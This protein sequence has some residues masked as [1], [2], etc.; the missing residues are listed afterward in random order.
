MDM[1]IYNLIQ[2]QRSPLSR[3][4]FRHWPPDN[5]SHDDD[6]IIE[7]QSPMFAQVL[8][9]LKSNGAWRFCVD[10]R[11][12][13]FSLRLAHFQHQGNALLNNSSSES[14]KTELE[15]LNSFAV[16]DLTS[17]CESQSLY[18]RTRSERYVFHYPQGYIQKIF[19][20]LTDHNITLGPVARNMTVVSEI[21]SRVCRSSDK[22]IFIAIQQGETRQ[23]G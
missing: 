1:Y 14:R 22:S 21:S 17:G 8:I 20:Q 11:T 5:P 16:L 13:K 18:S 9:T 23:V 10:Y 12:W 4:L 6:L 7:S 3:S 19:D 2:K 15:T